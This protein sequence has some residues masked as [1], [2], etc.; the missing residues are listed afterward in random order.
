M[1]E[2]VIGDAT[3]K[4]ILPQSFLDSIVREYSDRDLPYPLT[5]SVN[6]GSR[7]T[8]V[9]VREFS[10]EEGT[11]RL[12]IVVSENLAVKSGMSVSVCAIQLDK[13]ES[14][15]LR[16]LAAG[17]NLNQDWKVALEGAFRSQ[18]TTLTK[19]DVITLK[20][21]LR[22]LVD[23][24]APSDAV[25]IV[26]TDLEVDLEP[27]SEEQAIET[28]KANE[29]LKASSEPL[30]VSV[31]QTYEG[32]IDA[33]S[34]FLLHAW[35]RTKLLCVRLEGSLPDFAVA[36]GS[37]LEPVEL[38][39]NIW[40][41]MN[42]HLT[43]TIVIQPSNV[44]LADLSSLRINVISEQLG[45]FSLTVSQ[46]LQQD[47]SEPQVDGRD[48]V[49]C[50]NCL[51]MVPKRS[52]VLHER[53]CKRNNRKCLHDDCDFIYK[54]GLDTNHWHC[55]TCEEPG[56]GSLEL[57][58]ARFHTGQSCECNL[59]FPDL[60]TLAF[61]RAT[62]CPEK[63]TT[64]QFC[65]LLVPQGDVA[66]L[67]YTDRSL[68]F[69]PHESSCGARTTTCERCGRLCKLRDLATHLR[70]HE[71]AR[72]LHHAP[73]LCLNQN[74]VRATLSKTTAGT[75]TTGTTGTTQQ[76][77]PLGLCDRCF[78]PLYSAAQDEDGSK[79]LAR[80][81]RRYA[82]Q[83]MLG[84]RRAGCGNPFCASA[85]GRRLTF[86]EAAARVVEQLSGGGAGEEEQHRG[87]QQWFC[88]DEATQKLRVQAEV[89]AAEDEY[90]L[91]WCCR[92]LDLAGGHVDRARSW[93]ATEAVRTR[94]A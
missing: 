20:S 47:A 26:D 67:S 2:A 3:D 62:L 88:V 79:L 80:V 64:C 30:P 83:L 21:G 23:E 82:S 10:A 56:E 43:K 9:G 65:H 55:E 8:H 18:Y 50:D 58:H 73:P 60:P 76:Q 39:C 63:Q 94:E 24:L 36:I 45:P 93:L 85:T 28:V 40:T 78:G 74:C 70:I 54:K 86:A 6:N 51:V 22:F 52:L 92:A 5:F 29:A 87:R 17:Y 81:K 35:D 41:N 68:H 25:C 31:G 90:S 69:T 71:S 75:G 19:G 72:L 33:Q 27:L 37:G 15:R 16:P 48:D 1:S 57:H 84:C 77:L 11:V 14:V 89:V 91:A 38:R 66:Q 13:G 46:T 42:A 32:T 53:H 59:T 61:H 12:P 7:K 44:H 49:R 34:S 4:V